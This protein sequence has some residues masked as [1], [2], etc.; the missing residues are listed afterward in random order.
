MEFPITLETGVT[1]MDAKDPVW[2]NREKN[3][4]TCTVTLDG[5]GYFDKPT[6]VQFT[7]DPNDVMEHGRQLFEEL[8]GSAGEWVRPDVTVEDL[9]AEFDKIWPDVMLGLADQATIDLAKN[10]RVQIKAMS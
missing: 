5:G 10:L 4:I 7:A 1:L 6:E 8:K 2:A 3:L 9:Q